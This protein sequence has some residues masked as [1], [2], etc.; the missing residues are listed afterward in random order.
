MPAKLSISVSLS[1]L[2]A[3]CDFLKNPCHQPIKSI[4]MS[5][6][7][8]N[9]PDLPPKKDPFD[10]LECL[11]CST[12]SFNRN[13]DHTCVTA[14]NTNTVQCGSLSWYVEKCEN[15]IQKTYFVNKRQSLN[16]N[17]PKNLNSWKNFVFTLNL[18]ILPQYFGK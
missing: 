18:T 5:N 6:Y 9:A 7:E 2:S 4:F 3:K 12:T 13:K 14:S 17:N 10:E 16:K 8:N 1:D 15:S 11:A